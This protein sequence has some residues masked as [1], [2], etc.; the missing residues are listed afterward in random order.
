[1][2]Q[3]F[4]DF[5]LFSFEP[6]FSHYWRNKKAFPP[7]YGREGWLKTETGRA[8]SV[9]FSVTCVFVYFFGI[10]NHHANCNNDDEPNRK[11][12]QLPGCRPQQFMPSHVSPPQ[13]K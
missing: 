9:F 1:L 10:E 13:V 4:P 8:A 6:G 11:Q 7:F 5:R 2:I 12:A 3:T